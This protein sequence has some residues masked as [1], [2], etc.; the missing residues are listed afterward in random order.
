MPEAVLREYAA[1]AYLDP[2][3]F[4]DADGNLLPIHEMPEQGAA[5]GAF[6]SRLATC[7]HAA[8]SAT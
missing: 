4:Y 3:Q 1:F 8:L 7:N 2:A 5:R 6:R